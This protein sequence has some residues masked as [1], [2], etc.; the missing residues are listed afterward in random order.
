MLVQDLTPESENLLLQL[1]MN[2]AAC[3]L[4]VVMHLL[5]FFNALFLI[6]TRVI[7]TYFRCRTE[8]TYR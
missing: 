7:F 8:T 2:S 5:F 3:L 4:H 6:L 1:L